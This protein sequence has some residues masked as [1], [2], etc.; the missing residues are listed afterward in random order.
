MPDLKEN[1]LPEIL[2]IHEG[3][4]GIQICT[5]IPPERMDEIPSKLSNP[6]TSHGRW[7]FPDLKKHP[8]SKPAECTEYE[9]RWHYVLFC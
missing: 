7:E 4:L 2:V 6:G 5:T 8:E 9:G 1:D 3:L